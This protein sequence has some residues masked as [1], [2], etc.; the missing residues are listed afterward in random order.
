[1]LRSCAP[2]SASPRDCICAPSPKASKRARR[3]TSWSNTVATCSRAFCSP[4]RWSPTRSCPSRWPRTPTCCPGTTRRNAWAPRAEGRS[5][6]VG[7][8][9]LACDGLLVGGVPRRITACRRRHGRP[10]GVSQGDA[11]GQRRFEPL[12][13]EV[14]GAVVLRLLLRPHHLSELRIAGELPS[15]LV[16]RKR[17]ERL[18]AQDRQIGKA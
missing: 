5:R 14:P 4:G 18:R 10:A 17:I 11:G 3:P 1:M 13:H 7:A 8:E 2:R 15:Q 6:S 9:R 12:A 16:R